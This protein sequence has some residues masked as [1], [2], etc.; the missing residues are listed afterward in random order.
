MLVAVVLALAAVLVVLYL[1]DDR[2]S[3]PATV[4]TSTP[5]SQA[6]APQPIERD[7]STAL[8]AAL[9]NQVLGYSVSA[10]SIIDDSAWP[11]MPTE[12]WQLEYASADTTL[13]LV[14]T[15]WLTADEAD[16]GMQASPGMADAE[17]IGQVVVA[18]ETV[19][20]AVTIAA[21]GDFE[22]VLWRNGTAVFEV[23]GPPGTTRAFYYA[24][25]L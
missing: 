25:P 14:V 9:P 20:T 6:P 19:G 13:S 10:Q 4:A 2:S 7:T 8:L 1:T 12:Q 22:R 17:V 11:S 3:A 23:A 5:A 16:A 18:G 15:Q 24:Y 21:D